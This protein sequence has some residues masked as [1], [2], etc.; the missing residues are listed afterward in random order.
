MSRFS[1]FLG[2]SLAVAAL[3]VTT[4]F[5]Q[6]PARPADPGQARGARAHRFMAGLNLTDAQRE[7]IRTLRNE[8]RT[9]LRDQVRQ[10]RDAR[11]ALRAE[12]FADSPDAAKLQSLKEQVATLSQQVET[13]RLEMQ[14]EIAQILTPEQ[15][16]YMRDHQPQ[17]RR[18]G[19]RGRF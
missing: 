19:R 1:R 3:S 18:F 17:M 7:Q 4:G 9:A 10:L 6:A 15:R 13:R 8:H 16:Q 2:I 14:Q 12:T 11:R 5:A